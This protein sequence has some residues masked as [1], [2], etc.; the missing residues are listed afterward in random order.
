MGI[1]HE[2]DAVQEYVKFQHT[3]GCNGLF[4]CESGIHI[5]IDHPFLGATPD[6]CVYDPS[7]EEPYGFLEVKC[8]YLQTDNMPIEACRDSKFCCA[9]QK[10]G[11]LDMPTLKLNHPYYAQVQRQMA[12]SGRRWCDFVVFTPRGIS[13]E[14]IYFDDIYWSTRLLPKLHNFQ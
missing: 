5:S 7:A 3:N 13:V 9:V 4:V 8:P 12:I 11:E 2:E 1:D 14:R 6:G 10:K